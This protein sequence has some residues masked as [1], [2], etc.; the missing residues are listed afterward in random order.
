MWD[1]GFPPLSGKRPA[2]EKL[3]AAG[4]ILAHQDWMRMKCG[5]GLAITTAFGTVKA[6]V[7]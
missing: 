6:F 1:D 2:F 7:S 4:F 5:T 3:H